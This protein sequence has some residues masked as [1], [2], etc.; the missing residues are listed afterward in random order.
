MGPIDEV[1]I[2]PIERGLQKKTY[3]RIPEGKVEIKT[4]R[5]NN[6]YLS[7]TKRVYVRFEKKPKQKK[8]K[9]IKTEVKLGSLWSKTL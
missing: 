7:K 4:K 6:I 1:S 3:L 2:F 5:R 9:P 8:S